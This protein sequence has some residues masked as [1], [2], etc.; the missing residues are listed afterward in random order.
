MDNQDGLVKTKCDLSKAR[1]APYKNTLKHLQNT[2]CWC[3]LKLAQQRGLRFYQTRS[4][5][6]VLY[7]TLPA[8]FI[9][10]AIC[11][12]TKDQLFQRESA[13]VLFLIKI[14]SQ[15]GHKIYLY[16]KQDHLG[17][18]NKMLRA[19]GK[20]EATLLTTEYLVYRVQL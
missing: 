9:E 19:A 13:R 18:H 12:K 16:K 8:E 17:N 7:D 20:P 2:A 6:V 15:S 14:D 10:K 4:H 3:N 1:I 11:M 5:A